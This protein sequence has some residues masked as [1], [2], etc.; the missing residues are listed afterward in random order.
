MFYAA[1]NQ[2]HSKATPDITDGQAQESNESVTASTVY[3]PISQRVESDF[4][5]PAD[6]DN[7]KTN[8]TGSTEV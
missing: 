1:G 5:F 7:K 8:D 6:S 2:N 3:T 4:S